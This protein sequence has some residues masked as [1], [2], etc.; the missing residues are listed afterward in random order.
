[1]L[2]ALE[3][4]RARVAELQ[5]QIEQL[6][7]AVSQ[8]RFEH[9]KVQ[10]RLDAYTY[11][12][13]TLPNEIVSEIFVRVLPPYPYFP[14]LIGRL[15]P[16]PLTQICQRWREIAL[17]TPALWSALST[18]HTHEELALPIF[19]IWLKRSRHC[20]L[21]IR[22]G[23]GNAW[24]SDELIKAVIPHR[25]RWEY[26]N[27]GLV[28]K[29]IR[30]LDSPMPLLRHLELMVSSGPLADITL[31]QAPLLR[32][33]VLNRSAAT[34]ITFPWTQLTSLALFNATAPEC[35][36]IL[37]QTRTLVHCELQILF[38][39]TFGSQNQPE[40]T[41]P[42][43]ASL[44]LAPADYYYSLPNVLPTLIVPALH[45]LT[46]SESFLLPYPIDLLQAFI[47]KSRCTLE[48]L[49]LIGASSVSENSYRLAFPALRELSF[50]MDGVEEDL[51]DT[52]SDSAS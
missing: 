17:G 41:L 7:R 31:H 38:E 10:E 50:K 12:V 30:A 49:H 24:A 26:L 2:A 42:C 22:I 25:A 1:M 20:P 8:L 40:V 45:S 51:M 19:E 4:D 27:I 13:L 47:S 14:K 28:A 9:L 52:D 46:V 36:A 43:L 39:R 18:R 11:P 34:Q 33:L 37:A 16:T 21:S 6:E 44:V 5:S 23:R 32:T 35:L 15:S 48:E 29:D 3:T